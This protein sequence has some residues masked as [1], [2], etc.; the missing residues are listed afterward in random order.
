M[1]LLQSVFYINKDY[2]YVK[3]FTDSNISLD[4]IIITK[5]K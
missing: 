4:N 3:G 5:S 2:F 1:L